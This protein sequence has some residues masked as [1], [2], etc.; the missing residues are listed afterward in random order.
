M[1]S[2]DIHPT[3]GPEMPMDTNVLNS[4]A[5]PRR[6]S[7][8]IFWFWL[9]VILAIFYVIS[10]IDLLPD[11]VPVAGWIDDVVVALTAISIA[12]PKIIKYRQGR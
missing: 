2:H 1:K 8:N 7:A 9:M 6:R 4:S 3:S 5:R 10:P 12:L 11:L